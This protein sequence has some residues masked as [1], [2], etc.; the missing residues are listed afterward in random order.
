MQAATDGSTDFGA[1]S[2]N[3]STFFPILLHCAEF[4]RCVL[5]SISQEIRS[6]EP[7]GAVV[8]LGLP[9]LDRSK[10]SSLFAPPE[11]AKPQFFYLL[12]PPRRSRGRTRLE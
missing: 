10:P 12:M 6:P 4:L 3:Y 2:V 1:A 7:S 8:F 5:A 9:S 11:G